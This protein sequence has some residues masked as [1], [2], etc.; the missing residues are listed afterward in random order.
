[1]AGALLAR[2]LLTAR[3]TALGFDPRPISSLSFNLQM[4]GYDLGRAA[5]L[6]DRA[7][8]ALRALPGVTAVAT[9]SRLPLSPAIN[10]E[11]ILVAGHDAP[12]ADATPID[13]VRVGADYFTVVGV[14]IVAG[15]AFS[16]DDVAHQRRVAVV[17]ETF[18]R[19]YWAG[20]SAVG[21]RIYADG[22]D[23]EPTVVV[24]VAR[25]HRVRAVGEDPRP[26]LHRPSV[27]SRTI[28]LV[29]R[30]SVPS[31]SAL[32]MLRQAIL[33]LDPEILFTDETSAEDVVATTM[34]PTRIGA[35]VF[36]AFGL[37]ALLLAAVGLY[38]VIA[39]TVGRRTREIGVRIALGAGRGEVVRMIM[40]QG[41]RLAV[42]GIAVGTVGAAVAARVLEVLLYGVSGFD[43]I[44]YGVAAAMLLLVA[45][46][47]NLL[48]ALTAARVDPVHALRGD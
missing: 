27:P 12:G 28:G 7:L 16:E 10:M 9:A 38:G 23:K 25:D 44:A 11:G 4:N 2:G 41:G 34:A 22:F 6:Q 36:A 8:P 31:A 45:G 24:G 5:A 42:V 3:N 13:D 29:V 37:L 40:A 15:R 32:P 14:P 19:K 46:A 30:T 35:M 47:A 43:P 48:P 21:E 20:K 26:Y 1:V 33:T 39:Y 17:N 18:A